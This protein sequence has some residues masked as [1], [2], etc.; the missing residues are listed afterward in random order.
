MNDNDEFFAFPKIARLSR[1][2]VVT[3][4]LD[5]TNAQIVIDEDG[6]VRVG[7]RTRW[8]TPERD[9]YGLAGWVSRN[10]DEV[11]KLGPGRHFGEWWGAGIQRKYGLTGS[12]KRFSL[13][14]VHRWGD[15]A[16][17]FNGEGVP[18]PRRPAIFGVVP[19]LYRGPFDTAVIDGIIEKLR[20]EGSVA[21]PGFM[22]PE[23]IIVFHTA[24]GTMFKKTVL[25]DEKP[26][27]LVSE[28]A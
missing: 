15:D 10:I 5:G 13:F 18:Q 7:S 4:K 28:A 17:E 8:I 11:R 16:P 25:K 19:V 3:E 24:A 27:G 21:A 12:D 6:G 14:N 1:E 22:D 23:G 9:N 26:K 20:T 2:I